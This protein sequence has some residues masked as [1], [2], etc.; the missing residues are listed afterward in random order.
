MNAEWETSREVDVLFNPP[1]RDIAPVVPKDEDVRIKLEY[2]IV[3][4]LPGTKILCRM[5]S[6]SSP[7]VVLHPRTSALEKYERWTGLS[8]LRHSVK[9]ELEEIKYSLISFL[10]SYNTYHLISP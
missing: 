10:V 7:S 9:E 2:C 8:F 3:C 4:I 6:Q 1:L 5:S